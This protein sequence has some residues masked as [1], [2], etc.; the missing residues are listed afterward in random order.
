MAYRF[1]DRLAPLGMS[2]NSPIRLS[3]VRE[4]QRAWDMGVA[5]LQAR[6]RKVSLTRIL[7]TS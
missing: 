7:M 5:F 4:G 1:L 2:I 6:P 3:E